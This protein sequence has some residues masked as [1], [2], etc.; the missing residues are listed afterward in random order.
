M[1]KYVYKELIDLFLELGLEVERNL[2]TTN[3]AAQLMVY[4]NIVED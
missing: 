3:E 4:G 1:R 2:L